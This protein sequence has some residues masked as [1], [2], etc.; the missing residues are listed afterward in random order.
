VESIFGFLNHFY[1]TEKTMNK[2]AFTAL[3]A[4]AI[5]VTIANL[6]AGD[7][8]SHTLGIR[9]QA[10]SAETMTREQKE[11]FAEMS[12]NGTVTAI[13]PRVIYLNDPELV[14][15]YS[16]IGA[17]MAEIPF[18]PRHR[19]LAILVVARHWDAQYEWWAHESRAREAGISDA[20][21]EAIRV[22]RTPVFEKADE[23]II[24]DYAG[25]MM[26]TKRIT[27]ETYQKAWDLLETDTLIKLTMLIGHYCSV[28]VTLNAHEVPLPEGVVDPLPVPKPSTPFNQGTR[29]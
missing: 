16:V 5:C 29:K 1:E 20:V 28:A 3:F 25:E 10:P 2:I 17:Y 8:N 15:T 26:S 7:N 13:G 22:N 27:D 21:I 12:Q 6:A 4:I 19:E 14:K 9:I 24:Y 18:D 23:Q 11:L